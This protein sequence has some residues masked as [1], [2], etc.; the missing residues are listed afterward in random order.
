MGLGIGAGAGAAAG[1]M[2]VLLTR[3][4]DAVLARGTTLEMVLDR[5]VSFEDSELDFSHAA[6]P[7]AIAP[8]ASSRQTQQRRSWP[9][10]SPW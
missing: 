4:P 1:L 2:A 5:P 10:L 8:A 7:V 3:G 6:A 9:G